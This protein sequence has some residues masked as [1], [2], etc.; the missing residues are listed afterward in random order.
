MTTT[1]QAQKLASLLLDY[2]RSTNQTMLPPDLVKD[3]RSAASHEDESNTVIVT[4]VEELDAAD[5]KAVQAFV[6]KKVNEERR[7]VYKLDSSLVA[8]FT[9]KIGDELIDAS[10]KSKLTTLKDHLVFTT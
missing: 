9:L 6:L 7:I 10:L 5:K 3:L 1:K 4:S 2:L 8:G